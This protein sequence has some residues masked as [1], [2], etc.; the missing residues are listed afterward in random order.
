MLVKSKY[1]AV[2]AG[3]LSLATIWLGTENHS[4]SVVSFVRRSFSN[5][6]LWGLLRRVSAFRA[7]RS[8]ETSQFRLFFET[9]RLGELMEKRGI[10]HWRCTLQKTHF[11]T[12]FS[13]TVPLPGLEEVRTTNCPG[14]AEISLR[15]NYSAEA[16][17]ASPVPLGARCANMREMSECKQNNARIVP[18]QLTSSAI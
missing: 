2:S 16:P 3:S 6:L 1:V 13:E 17:C 5:F 9:E 18:F 8:S 4:C 11:P 7:R 15:T 14:S 10:R 12:D